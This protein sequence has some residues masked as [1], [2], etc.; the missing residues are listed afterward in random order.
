MWSIDVGLVEVSSAAEYD[1][2]AWLYR[3]LLL[4]SSFPVKTAEGPS[5]NWSAVPE[6]G[7]RQFPPASKRHFATNSPNF[8]L[9]SASSLLVCVELRL[10]A[11]PRGHE[12]CTWNFTHMGLPLNFGT[13][14]MFLLNIAMSS[15]GLI[16]DGSA[17][18]EFTSG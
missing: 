13:E 5:R 3:F 4:L 8:F 16:Q 18:L 15:P 6:G 1:A 17:G 12:P 11:D 9:V 2:T 14:M 10:Q 7:P